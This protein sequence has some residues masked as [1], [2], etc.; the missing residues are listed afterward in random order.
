MENKDARKINRSTD[1]E[2]LGNP[3][4]LHDK[5]GNGYIINTDYIEELQERREVSEE[6]KLDLQLARELLNSNLRQLTRK[7]RDVMAYSME[8]L[9]RKE[10]AGKMSIGLSMVDKHLKA[11]KRKLS[12]LITTT[13]E[14]IKEIQDGN[15]S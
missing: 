10:M 13:K 2:R 7:Q 8:G 3:E 5:W 14:I 9:T 15:N 11:A 12:K 4:L 1:D 6:K